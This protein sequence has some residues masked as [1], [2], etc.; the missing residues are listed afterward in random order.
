MIL[1]LKSSYNLLQILGKAPNTFIAVGT[2]PKITE[3]TVTLIRH[4]ASG[5]NKP[6]TQY[7]GS[8]PIKLT[9]PDGINTK[10]IKWIS[11]WNKPTS[12]SLGEIH[13]PGNHMT[14][15]IP[16]VP[17][18]KTSTHILHPGINGT[19]LII[20]NFSLSFQINPLVHAMIL[21]VH[22]SFRQKQMGG[23]NEYRS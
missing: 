15:K 10:N 3:S 8:K 23:G 9:L 12:M 5:E 16:P 2:D 21:S 17:S 1:L 4:P 20:L 18:S 11:I 22:F 13:F 19:C 6:L 14:H 7:D